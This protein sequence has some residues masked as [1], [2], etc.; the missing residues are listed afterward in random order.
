[1][2]SEG[3]ETEKRRNGGGGKASEGICPQGKPSPTLQANK[4]NEFH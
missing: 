4:Y 3:R 1:M 2:F